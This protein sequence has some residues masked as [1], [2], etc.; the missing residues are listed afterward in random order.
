MD[1]LVESLNNVWIISLALQLNSF[2]FS[3]E[4]QR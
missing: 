3:Q 1:M 4:L 2:S